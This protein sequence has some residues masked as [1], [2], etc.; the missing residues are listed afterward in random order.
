MRYVIRYYHETP[1]ADHLPAFLHQPD[2]V[3]LTT[4]L[5]RVVGTAR[6]ERILSAEQ[7][8]PRQQLD[9]EETFTIALKMP[10]LKTGC[11]S[12]RCGTGQ[13]Q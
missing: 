6:E 3:A 8:A 13:G 5:I 11:L 9:R 4:I 1:R 2:V 12:Y 7:Q 10:A